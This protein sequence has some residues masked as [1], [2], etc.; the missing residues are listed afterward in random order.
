MNVDKAL[1]NF[2]NYEEVVTLARE[3]WNTEVSC[4]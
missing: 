2:R 1:A 3:G 4:S